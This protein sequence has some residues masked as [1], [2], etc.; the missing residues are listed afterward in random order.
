MSD[1]EAQ[2]DKATADESK[3]VRAKIGEIDKYVGWY[4]ILWRKPAGEDQPKMQVAKIISV[5]MSKRKI[6]Y[7]VI[8]G[9]NKGTRRTSK[10]EASQDID[11]YD[12]ETKVYAM[13][14]TE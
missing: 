10:Y 11:V 5:E 6:V 8:S 1:K 12:E 14:R 9:A 7:E 13:L 3:V 2:A 4:T